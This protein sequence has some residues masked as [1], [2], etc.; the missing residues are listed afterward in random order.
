M[1][2]RNHPD[3][4]PI[5]RTAGLV[6]DTWTL[7]ILRDLGRR[8]CRFNELFGSLEGVSSRTLSQRLRM[9]EAAGVVE[10]EC[11]AEVPPRVEYALTG[12]GKALLPL[13]EEM[14]SFGEE[15]LPRPV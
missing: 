15:W 6:G 14:R 2:R 1:A 12:K 11:Y 5:A 3:S 8:R 7:L 9:L 10:R 4:C 13:V